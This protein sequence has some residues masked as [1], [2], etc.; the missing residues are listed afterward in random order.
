MKKKIDLLFLFYIGLI[1]TSTCIL[2]MW[3]TPY[4]S[5]VSPDST[6]YIGGANSLVSGK[7]YSITHYPPLYPFFLAI[8]SLLKNNY[9]QAARFLNAILFGLNAGLLAFAVFL[10]T[11]RN[12]FSTT[13]AAFFFFSSA[14]LLVVHSWAWSEP[15][16]IAFSLTCIILLSVYITK[17]K[18]PFLIASSLSLGYAL[19]TRYIGLA[20][21]PAA[22]IV[23]F[24][25]EFSRPL[26]RRLSDTLIYF[27][28]A[29]T[30]LGFFIMRNMIMA[31]SAT[32]R[33]MAFHPVSAFSFFRDSISIVLFFIAPF[34]LPS[35]MRPLIFG[36]FAIFL[37][38]GV[39]FWVK[40][41]HITFSDINWHSLDIKISIVSLVLSLSYLLFLFISIT[42][43][44]AATP[45][46]NRLLSPLFVFLILLAFS[47]IWAASQ[48]LKKPIIWWCFLLLASLSIIIK[49]PEAI[50]SAVDIRENGLGYTSRQWQES[51]G[52]AY[53]K[54]ITTEDDRSIYSNGS[55]VVNFLTGKES[56]AIPIK[57]SASTREKNQSYDKEIGAMCKEIREGKAFLFYFNT[58]TH[59]K[60]LPTEDEIEATCNL[61]VL[62]LFSDGTAFG[63]LQR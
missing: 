33:H 49:I 9:V 1:V 63:I 5:G 22:L 62:K 31:G 34:S 43:F 32:N 21:L 36:L 15:L 13:L 57:Y 25:G 61:P 52:V 40:R 58:I 55:D 59:R 11:G 2:I 7:G 24:L 17:P 23:V 56:Q 42:F 3:I 53:L 29:S 50:R 54:S 28:F 6:T 30:P 37:L 41:Q 12:Y 14:P 16:F 10:T 35:G 20:F 44:D 46:D 51:E 19:L 45:V 48:T 39:A 38:I 26:S 18:L 60:Y 8:M 4:G 47:A 27:I